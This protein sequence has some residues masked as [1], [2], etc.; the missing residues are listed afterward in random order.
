ML[1]LRKHNNLLSGLKAKLS[2]DLAGMTSQGFRCKKKCYWGS[3][4]QHIVK[5]TGAWWYSQPWPGTSLLKRQQQIYCWQHKWAQSYRKK[6]IWLR[7]PSQLGV[8]DF[9]RGAGSFPWLLTEIRIAVCYRYINQSFPLAAGMYLCY[10]AFLG[11]FPVCP[12]SGPTLTAC[13]VWLRY[14]GKQKPSMRIPPRTLLIAQP[15]AC[16]GPWWLTFQ[17]FGNG[18]CAPCLT[19]NWRRCWCYGT[20][21]RQTCGHRRELFSIWGSLLDIPWTV[22][23]DLS[24]L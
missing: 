8:R 21:W 22:L 20:G 5:R 4:S 6:T 10:S 24:Y 15:R 16:W 9:E 7:R 11:R 1:I 23:L 19:A 3:P 2:H 12:T 18:C 17:G 13:L 14:L